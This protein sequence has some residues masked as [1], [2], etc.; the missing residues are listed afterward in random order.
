MKHLKSLA[1][2]LLTLSLGGCVRM[3]IAWAPDAPR[4]Q[5]ATPSVLQPLGGG[6][7]ITS[8]AEWEAERST[9]A[10]ALQKDVYGM[11]PAERDV[12]VRAHRVID[13]AALN[14]QAIYEEYDLV[15]TPIFSGEVEPI[16]RG[17]TLAVLRPAGSAAN[18]PVIMTET[19]CP[20]WAALPH[21]Q[22]TK[23]AGTEDAGEMPG[24][25][26]YLFGRYICTPP[27][28]T[29][30]ARGYA[31]AVIASTDV[32][33]D[34]GEAGLAALGQ[35]AS[36]FDDQDTRWGAIA[37]WGWVFSGMADVLLAED[38]F[39]DSP[40][41]AYG[42]SRYG[43]AALVAGAFDERIDA[44]IAH[45]SGTGGASLNRRKVGESV[46]AITKSYPHWFAAN[47]ARYAGRED[48]MAVD[49]HHLLALIAPRPVLL[50]NA[51]RDVWSDP[52]GAF[53]AA[54]GA[55]PVYELYGRQG[56]ATARLDDFDP[57]ADL[58]FWLRPGTHGVVEEDWPA[59]LQFLDAHVAPR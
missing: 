57:E 56:L 8:V 51:R 21:P 29:I 26:S 24:F 28:E 15:F 23:P 47:Y 2:L 33:P 7:E 39:S 27:L 48:A 3:T 58:S 52:N 18:A 22:A 59:F 43:K 20:R 38:H 6:D 36:G 42:H 1:V 9:V 34:R 12:S 49:Q 46:K 50:G 35:L 32:V 30:I 54:Q 19:F 53:K 10:E 5:A 11:L 31:L 25:V 44:V 17:A 37:A 4:G 14:G 41:I 16:G 45:Q 40:L 13:T 55:D